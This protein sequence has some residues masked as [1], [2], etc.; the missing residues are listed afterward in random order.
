MTALRVEIDGTPVDCARS[1]ANVRITF[2]G[3]FD[4]RQELNPA[5]CQASFILPLDVA[6]PEPGQ[7]FAVIAT[8][9]GNDVPR[10]TGTI[11]RARTSFDRRGLAEPVSDVLAVGDLSRLARIYV[12]AEPWPVETDG[13]R[14]GRILAL[15]AAQ[16]PALSWSTSP[17]R[18]NVRPRDVD[19]QP[20]GALLTEL[21]ETALGVVT[22]RR[23]GGIAYLDAANLANVPPYVALDACHVLTDG[24][25]IEAASDA[26]VNDVEVLYGAPA[27]P[28]DDTTRPRVRLTAADSIARFGVWA[29]RFTTELATA[30][31]AVDFA[32]AV[33]A[34]SAWPV[35]TIPTAYVT[36]KS[37]GAIGPDF[38]AGLDVLARLTLTGLPMPGPAGLD[39]S[40]NGYAE[41]W[42]GADTWRVDLTLT[43][44]R[45]RGL[46]TRWVD[47]PCVTWAEVPDDV[48]WNA[49]DL[50]APCPPQS[51]RWIDTPG[52]LLW[53]AAG[54]TPW[55]EWSTVP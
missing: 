20:A 29:D 17:G 46:G 6:P 33:L 52:N 15:A 2:G 43:D 1:L 55:Q 10:F 47:V 36:S 54:G 30:G 37:A 51:G 25:G 41:T 42:T 49:A 26:L 9:D 31:D 40:V 53:N 5:T 12:G 35:A 3:A 18:V 45:T 32:T 7:R 21:A 24:Y 4:A 14:A 44:V 34:R 50:W 16:W 28:G 11:E 27:V 38:L 39:A 13:D 8:L 19:R 48:T 22:D 23:A